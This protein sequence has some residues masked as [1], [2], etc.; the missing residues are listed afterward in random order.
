MGS[1]TLDT[2]QQ[3]DEGPALIR[4]RNFSLADW[5]SAAVEAW[6]AGD[7]SGGYRGTLEIFTGGGKTLIALACIER[8]ASLE[9]T[10]RAAI[11][12]PTEALAHQWR[13]AIAEFTSVQ[14]ADVGLLGAGGH[15]DLRSKRV[16]VAVLNSAARELP[17]MIARLDAPTILVVDECHRAGAAS[18][19]RVLSASSTFRLGLSATPDREELDDDGE[20]LEYDEQL[21]GRSLGAVVFRFGLR[22]A[23]SVEWLPEFTVHHHAVELVAPERSEYDRLSRQIDDLADRLGDLGGDASRARTL[24]SQPGDLGR[25]A[26][27]YVAATAKRK[28]LLYRAQER[29]RITVSLLARIVDARPGTRALTFHERIAE[30]IELERLLASALP[31]RVAIEHSR[32][33]ASERRAT[34]DAFRNGSVQ[35]LVS[36]KSL[37]EG[38]DVP[39]ADV[40]VSVASSSS[41]RQRIQSLGRVLRRS[42]DVPDKVAEMH[43]I[44]VHD[45]V[46]ESIYAKED[47]SDLTGEAANRYWLWPTAP[48]EAPE[49]RDGPP[50]SP[51]PTE[52]QEWDRLGAVAPNAPVAY[53]GVQPDREYSVDTTGTVR[54][55]SGALVANA[56]GVDGMVTSVRGRPGGR[57]FITPRYR[58]VLVREGMQGGRLMAAGQLA[59]PFSIRPLEKDV[60][61][62]ATASLSPGAT[63]FGPL[64]K[65]NGEY[66]LSQKR[67]GVVQRDVAGGAKEFALID[68]NRQAMSANL[69]AVLDAWRSVAS[70]GIKFAVNNEWHAWYVAGG[71]PRFLAA[72]PGGFAWPSDS[73]EGG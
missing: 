45:S 62:H 14:I 49:L 35:V 50:R 12:V 22:E 16:L 18:F 53:L 36:V 72:V 58:L 3:A 1:T 19:S 40:G 59:E 42:S 66:R 32:L 34:L 29:S 41:V 38:I 67:G 57:F 4:T 64:D 25:A 33:P 13:T 30:A 52:E 60:D 11:V 46:D 10:L 69:A 2:A 73:E 15:D 43:V 17:E 56:Q 20:P 48:G 47:W 65:T 8:A 51:A 55:E 7:G 54:T 31:V 28:D 39:N 21:V 5:Q 23:R 27:A 37:I 24:A 61:A 63:Y 44:Y 6:T 70:A 68:A 26:G 71:E 9:P